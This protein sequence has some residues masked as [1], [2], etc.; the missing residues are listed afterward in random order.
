MTISGIGLIFSTFIVSTMLWG[1]IF[2]TKTI[3]I[4]EYEVS[5]K[6]LP[7][8]FNNYRIVQFSDLHISSFNSDQNFISTLSDRI[9]SLNPDL[10]VF[11]GDFV[12]LNSTELTPFIDKLS[13][14][15]SKDGIFAVL[16]NHDYSE[17]SRWLTPEEKDLDFSN[18]KSSITSLNWK[19]LLDESLHIYRETDSIILSGIENWGEAPFSQHGDL[20]KTFSKIKPDIND[21]TILL[22]HNPEFWRQIVSKDKQPIDLTLSGH[23]HAMQLIVKFAGKYYS[24]STLKYKCW[25]GLYTN[26]SNQHLIVNRGIGN[27]FYHMR[28][29][30]PPEISLIKL[31]HQ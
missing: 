7:Y 22:S 15:K 9:N 30:A 18:L 23:T 29:G 3:S 12:T 19:L 31:I 24:P 1:H 4:E 11:T 26:E 13:T 17:Y 27:V 16:G 10:V 25:G 14:I 8:S 2:E 20:N 28:I 21:F 6:K 5:S